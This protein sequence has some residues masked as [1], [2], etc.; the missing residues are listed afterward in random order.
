[1]ALCYNFTRVL[2]ILGIDRFVAYMAA[3][4]SAVRQAVHKDVHAVAQRSIQRV[5]EALWAYIASQIRVSRLRGIPAASKDS[6]WAVLNAFS[7][8]DALGFV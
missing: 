5:L 2:N 1:M 6:Y 7:S 4:A 8:K 3:K